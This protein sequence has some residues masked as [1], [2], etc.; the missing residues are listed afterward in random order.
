MA[1]GDLNIALILKLVDQATGPA[2][3]VTNSLRQIGAVTEQTG[4]AGVAWAN[5]Q[6][7]ANQA[8]RSALMGE[9]FGIAALAGSLAA[10]LRP[11]IDFERAMAEV[12]AVARADDEELARLT[13]TARELGATTPW[14]A[15]EA[16]AGM[17]FL[18]MAGFEASETIDAM[19][20]MLQLASAGAI[21]LARASDIASNILTGFGMQAGEMGYL[22]DV[23]TNTFT[24][25]NTDLGMLGE[26]MKYVAPN[27]QA[28]G[29]SLEQTAAMAGKLGDAGIQ[30]S[31]AGTALR[32]MMLRLAALPKPAADAMAELGIRTVDASGN[33]RDMPTILAEV[34]EAL[35]KL[36]TGEQAKLINDILAWKPPAPLL[37]CSKKLAAARCKTMPRV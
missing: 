14:A 11:A 3:A 19:P 9:A 33:L 15:S 21:D 30:G 18:A 17:K 36:G 10:S 23:L 7:A 31:Q 5:E 24:S 16:A 35:Q 12:A 25:S 27:A 32:A 34:H 22:G 4:R 26:T 2:R 8:R 6:L 13:E 29:V 37:F 28:L 20:G 1:A